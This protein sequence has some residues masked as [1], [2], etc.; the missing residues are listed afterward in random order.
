MET[1]G[2]VKGVES[3]EAATSLSPTSLSIR[4][5]L[6]IE[7]VGD[8]KSEG[9]AD[10]FF[11][12]VAVVGRE[13]LGCVGE[14]DAEKEFEFDWVVVSGDVAMIGFVAVDVMRIEGI[15]FAGGESEVVVI[16]VAEIVA[17]FEVNEEKG[18]E[19]EEETTGEIPPDW[20]SKVPIR[21]VVCG[22]CIDCGGDISEI[23]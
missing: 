21:L 9:G 5:F 12:F 7:P 22:C 17:C 10:V 2:V 6:L 19:A 11:K 1:D 14:T 16:A 20:F 8:E 3:K 15:K 18:V 23:D 4:G 13:E